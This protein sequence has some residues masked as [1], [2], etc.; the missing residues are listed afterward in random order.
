MFVVP[1]HFCNGCNIVCALNAIHAIK[2]GERT[3]CVAVKLIEVA[4]QRGIPCVTVSQ[5]IYAITNSRCI[6]V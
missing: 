5:N 2:L 6:P 1:L 3:V 4:E